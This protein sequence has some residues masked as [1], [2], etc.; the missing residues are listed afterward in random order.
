MFLGKYLMKKCLAL[1]LQEMIQND[2]SSELE[3]Q[4]LEKT[5]FLTFLTK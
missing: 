4:D 5:S 1:N 2:L 3:H